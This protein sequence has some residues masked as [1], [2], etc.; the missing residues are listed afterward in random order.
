MVVWRFGLAKYFDFNLAVL[1]LHTIYNLAKHTLSSF[2]QLGHSCIHLHMF[3]C[4][5]WSGQHLGSVSFSFTLRSSIGPTLHPAS[6]DPHGG[7]VSTFHRSIWASNYFA[8]DFVRRHV[9]TDDCLQR[10]CVF[11]CVPI[12]HVTHTSIWK[13][14]AETKRPKKRRLFALIFISGTQDVKHLPSS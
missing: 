11:V 4:L 13:M 10:L 6:I 7:M 2:H 12:Q 5:R 8:P 1:T 14:G 9:T 3:A